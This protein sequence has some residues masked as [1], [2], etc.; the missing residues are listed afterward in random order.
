MKQ[1]KSSGMMLCVAAAALGSA[2][3]M[4]AGCSSD[5]TTVVPSTPKIATVTFTNMSAAKTDDERATVYSGSSAV[6]TFTDGKTK[7]YPLSYKTLF[8]SSDVISGIIPGGVVDY[9]GA[10]IMDTSVAGKTTPFISDAPDANSLLKVD[11]APATGLGG[12]PLYLVTHYEYQTLDNSG[13][14]RYG[15]L[16]MTMSLATLDQNKTDGSLAVARMKKIDFSSVGGLWIPCAGSLSP[17]NTHLGSEEY[18][19]DARAVEAGGT[20]STS[21]L[22]ILTPM[23]LYYSNLLLTLSPYN[24]GISPEVIINADGSTV[25]LKHYSMGRIARELNQVMPDNRTVYMGDDGD[26][27][28][29]FMYVADKEKDLSS[30]TLYAGKW[31]Q[32]SNIGAGEASLTWYRLGHASD[33]EIKALTTLKFSDIFETTTADTIGFSKIKTNN[34]SGTTGVA[35]EWL[36]L[37][38]GMEKAAAFLE[39]RRYAA[40][41]GATTEFNKMEGVS[42]NAKDKKVYLAMTRIQNG[43]EDKSTGAT[44]DPVN[45]IN[46]P[47]LLAGAVYELSLTGGQA[48]LSGTAI[49]SQYV[50]TYM[51]GLL[52]GQDIAADAVGNTAHIDKISNPDNLKYSETMRTLFIGE[53]SGQHVNNYLWAYNVDTKTLSRILSIPAGAESTGLQVVENLNG[54]PY[55]MSNFQHPADWGSIKTIE[56]GLKA[57]LQ[58]KMLDSGL[59]VTTS[60]GVRPAKGAIGYLSGLPILQ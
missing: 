28:G 54:F 21:G 45:N 42:V 35:V 37:K 58:Q 46:L 7:T 1:Q 9:S 3:L 30:G 17:W 31:E 52:I 6:V 23:T 41:L 59:A 4:A 11:G 25:V 47:K 29:L 44:P 16:P 49:N 5:S 43:M 2:A 13:T 60:I 19:P 34:N 56:A 36:K 48:D 50:A 57:R 39:T 20:Y 14:S 18:E 27:T 8:Q 33:A 24:Y 10:A 26:Y 40:I 15:L 12:N 38:P 22:P 51:S 32:K 53:D 55:I